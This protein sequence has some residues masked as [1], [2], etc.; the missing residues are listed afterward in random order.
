MGYAHIIIIRGLRYIHWRIVRMIRRAL[1]AMRGRKRIHSVSSREYKY[2]VFLKPRPAGREFQDIKE[3][4]ITCSGKRKRIIQKFSLL[5]NTLRKEKESETWIQARC[6]EES[7]RKIRHWSWQDYVYR[8]M[9][10][11]FTGLFF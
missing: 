9:N 6:G 8:R 3:G 4:G 10:R 11:P 2:G 5:R 7:Q 1:I